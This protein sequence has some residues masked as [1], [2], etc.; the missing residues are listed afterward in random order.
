MVAPIQPFPRAH[1]FLLTDSVPIDDGAIQGAH[2]SDAVHPVPRAAALPFSVP[3]TAVCLGSSKRWPV[4][5][6]LM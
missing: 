3:T 6:L 5:N 1:T 4:S 2:V